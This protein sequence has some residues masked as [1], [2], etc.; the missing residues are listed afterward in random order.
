M[1]ITKVAKNN[2]SFIEYLF[3]PTIE[4]AVALTVIR[5]LKFKV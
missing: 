4:V 1:K 5:S 3:G 2:L